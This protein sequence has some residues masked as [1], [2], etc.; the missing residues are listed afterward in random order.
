MTG[1]IT[2]SPSEYC[3][4]CFGRLH[5]A[6][7]QGSCFKCFHD[8]PPDNVEERYAAAL[9]D[10]QWRAEQAA[11]FDPASRRGALWRC[12]R[13]EQ[14]QTLDS[15]GRI[16]THFRDTLYGG[17]QWCFGSGFQPCWDSKD[18]WPATSE[19]S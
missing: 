3:M 18:A 15:R 4:S 17:R 8:G 9:A 11:A 13:C 2:L 6:E 7:R 19:E 10:A 5:P 14:C 12:Y 1:E 16:P